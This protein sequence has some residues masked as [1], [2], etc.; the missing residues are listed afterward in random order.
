MEIAYDEIKTQQ[1]ATLRGQTP[2]VLR[3][4]RP[5]LVRQEL[6]ALVISYNA[7]RQLMRQAA[8]LEEKEVTNL[9]FGDCLQELL[10][11]IPLLSC[12]GARR[13]AQA[14]LLARLAWCEIDRPRRPRSN[15]RVVK[16]KLAKFRRK[17]GVGQGFS[18]DFEQ[19][20]VIG[21]ARSNAGAGEVLRFPA[22][23]PGQRTAWPGALGSVATAKPAAGAKA[24][25]KA[26]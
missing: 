18:Y 7:V 8:A 16:V 17:V 9:S 5:D 23:A 25:K 24:Q 11:A 21:P 6:Y 13:R 26:A 1:A 15:P 22:A 19:D 4:K 2:T 12:P 10:D 14:Y 3:S 20:L